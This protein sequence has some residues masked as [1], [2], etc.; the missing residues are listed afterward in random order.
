MKNLIDI[1]THTVLSEHAYSTFLENV[2]QASNIGLK[3]YGVSDHAYGLTG[4]ISF[5]SLSNLKILPKEYNNV[6]ILKGVELNIMDINGKVD[7]TIEQMSSIDYAV[8][9]IHTAA[10][11]DE[12]TI[13]NCT[14]AY[15]NVLDNPKVKVL[16][17]ID[18][19]NTL[20]NYEPVI[21]KAKTNKI[22]IELNNSSLLTGYRKNSRT[23]MLEI[24]RLCKLHNVP[25]II[26]SDAHFLTSVG[27]YEDVYE[28][29]KESNFPTQ[30][31]ANFNED[32][33]LEYLY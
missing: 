2:N 31:I 28:L 24:I 9:S 19:G 27:K 1:H 32:I 7:F 12:L 4:G 14:K 5:Y 33:I 17:H 23:N 6:K 21:L 10:F 11:K 16:G 30:L 20:S 29:I 26:N 13:E 25:V 18:D 22:L 8:A 3:Y 15:L